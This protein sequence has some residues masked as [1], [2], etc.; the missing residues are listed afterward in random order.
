MAKPLLIINK[1]AAD[2][3]FTSA[4]EEDGSPGVAIRLTTYLP[5]E[6]SQ[7]GSV[8]L[9]NYEACELYFALK[10]HLGMEDD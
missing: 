8:L 1:V 7:V 4:A 9:D 10:D 2:L 5:G 6:Y 3:T